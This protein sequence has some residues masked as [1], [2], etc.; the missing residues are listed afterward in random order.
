MEKRELAASG[1]AAE[2]GEA[3]VLLEAGDEEGFVAPPEAPHLVAVHA[4]LPLRVPRF[5]DTVWLLA[6][7]GYWLEASI[8]ASVCHEI[9]GDER[10]LLGGTARLIANKALG[11]TKLH[12][13][14]FVGNTPRALALLNCGRPS[15]VHSADLNIATARFPELDGTYRMT[16]LRPLDFAVSGGHAEIARELVAR[17]ADITSLRLRLLS[18]QRRRRQGFIRDRKPDVEDEE[19]RADREATAKSKMLLCEL[20]RLPSVSAGGALKCA[21]RYNLI[22]IVH[23]KLADGAIENG[24]TIAFAGNEGTSFDVTF[25][26]KDKIGVSF[27]ANQRISM[28][29]AGGQAYLRGL[30]RFDSISHVGGTA[31]AGKSDVEQAA[32]VKAARSS[33][34]GSWSITVS[35]PSSTTLSS[36]LA[37]T[38]EAEELSVRVFDMQQDSNSEPAL[39]E[40]VKLPHQIVNALEVNRELGSEAWVR[41]LCTEANLEDAQ[42]RDNCFHAAASAGAVDLVQECLRRGV[43]VN[44]SRTDPAHVDMAILKAADKNHA[45]VVA[46]LCRV[47]NISIN[48]ALMSACICGLV[49]EAEALC[50]RGADFDFYDEHTYHGALVSSAKA[51]H[52][53]VVRLLCS[54]GA[55]LGATGNQAGR[56]LESPLEA[57]CE[58]GCAHTAAVLI[59]AGAD[60][61]CGAL[62]A[63]IENGHVE[64]FQLLCESGAAANCAVPACRKFFWAGRRTVAALQIEDGEP[65][66]VSIRP[67]ALACVCGRTD[68]AAELL[69]RGAQRNAADSG[70]CTALMGACIEGLDAV[71]LLLL[72][73]AAGAVAGTPKAAGMN[74][75]DINLRDVAGRSALAWACMK[76]RAGCVQLLLARAD[77][78]LAA[79]DARGYTAADLALGHAG[80]LELLRIKGLVPS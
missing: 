64:C 53:D 40:L 38:E 3:A 22:E 57:A 31:L 13:A 45:E 14:C 10:V 35:R 39:R 20:L 58:A 52:T 4:R 8:G 66:T 70:G 46:L 16:N 27:Y 54:Q 56:R 80:I 12:H 49:K 61:D 19:G 1:V 6:E 5:A 37:E 44:S 67:L 43:D 34:S 26:T 71:V 59:S 51:G 41:E 73:P 50:H 33:A 47:P 42:T 36:L 69:R 72:S 60:V 7:A 55:F 2:P 9:Y 21:L 15:F 63:A 77:L 74:A 62:Y 29:A 78:D 79:R 32:I 76:R 75:L 30:R 18:S 65:R 24:W 23:E 68:F 11:R 17:G 48:I 25:D 28:V